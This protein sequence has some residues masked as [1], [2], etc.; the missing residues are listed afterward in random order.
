MVNSLKSSHKKILIVIVAL[1]V[2]LGGGMWLRHAGSGGP[3]ASKAGPPGGPGGSAPPAMTVRVAEV[4]SAA[5]REDVTAIG[6][7]LANESISIRSEVYGR[8]TQNHNREG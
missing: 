2:L 6:T 5:L 8:I 4:K 3:P 1:L 7:L